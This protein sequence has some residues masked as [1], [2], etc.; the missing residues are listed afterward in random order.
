MAEWHYIGN[1]GQVGPIKEEQLRELASFGGVTRETLVWRPGLAQ[2]VRAGDLPELSGLFDRSVPPAPPPPFGKAPLP[3]SVGL[4][5]QPV[6]ASLE[7]RRSRIATGL[8]QICLPGVGR[9]YAGF[10]G[11]GVA[12]LVV[13]IVTCGYGALWSFVDGILILTGNV[14]TDGRGLPFKE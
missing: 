13:A 7:P 14:R 9:M 2:W 10:V 11:M 8:L 12:Q 4:D 5:S 1:Y 3:P 6:P